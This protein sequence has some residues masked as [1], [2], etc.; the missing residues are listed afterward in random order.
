[1]SV[2]IK[3]RVLLGLKIKVKDI[4]QWKKVRACSHSVDETLNFCPVCGLPI[5]RKEWGCKLPAFSEYDEEYQGLDV[6]SVKR[7]NTLDYYIFGSKLKVIC[8]GDDVF[9]LSP[10]YDFSRVKGRVK[11]VFHPL[12]MWDESHFGLYMDLRVS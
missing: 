7:E 4:I 10:N 5:F 9:F 1:M 2:S 11:Q 6:F 12:G 8:P 3:T